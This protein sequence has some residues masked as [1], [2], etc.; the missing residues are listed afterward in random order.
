MKVKLLSGED[1]ITKEISSFQLSSL[2]DYSP[3]FK[4]LLKKNIIEVDLS[5][6]KESVFN[7][8]LLYTSEYKRQPLTCFEVLE[9]RELTSYLG[10][11]YKYECIP[12]IYATSE[13]NSKKRKMSFTCLEDENSKNIHFVKDKII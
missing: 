1:I 3:L 9:L 5:L 2:A 10:I 12:I 8:I 7:H 6:F 11:K 13:T 4:N